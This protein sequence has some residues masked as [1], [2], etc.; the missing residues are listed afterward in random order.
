MA[1]IILL[2]NG[3]ALLHDKD[4]HVH[5]TRTDILIEGGSIAKIERNISAPSGA[6]VIDCVDKIISPGFI[7]TH[8]H[9]WQTQTR[10]RFGDTMLMDYMLKGMM[11]GSNFSASD[12]FWGQL[13]GCMEVIDAGTTTV[14]DQ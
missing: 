11:Q 2:Q 13:G 7:D 1:S 9:L 10:A 6:Q 4:D 12:V 5:P 8:H 3:I 14:V